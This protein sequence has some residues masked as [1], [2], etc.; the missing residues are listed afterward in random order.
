MSGGG[1]LVSVCLCEGGEGTRE[2]N[3]KE[4]AVP[5]DKR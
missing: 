5:E 3:L 1:D 2:E 4:G